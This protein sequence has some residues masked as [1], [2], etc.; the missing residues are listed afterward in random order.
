MV[1]RAALRLRLAQRIS[2]KS[3]LAELDTEEGEIFSTERGETCE[4]GEATEEE[5]E[6]AGGRG[7]GRWA[8]ERQSTRGQ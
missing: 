5:E 3:G 8:G 7:L 2:T 6:G 4:G 1:Q